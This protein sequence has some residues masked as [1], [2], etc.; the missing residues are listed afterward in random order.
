MRLGEGGG[1]L[2]AAGIRVHRDSG[3]LAHTDSL[4][5]VYVDAFGAPPWH[6]DEARATGFVS[7]LSADVRRAGF[8][9]AIA[10]CDGE[11]VGF[12]TAWTTP[13]PFPTNRCHPEAAAGLGRDRTADWLCGGREIDELAVRPAAHGTGLAGRLLEAVT[14]DAPEGRAWLLTSVRSG[15]ALAFYRRHGWT[16]ATHP[17]PGGKGIVVFL[18]PHHPARSLAPLPL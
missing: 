9:A 18:G 10:V 15:R 11:V 12:A 16:Q 7:R 4:R 5:S 13:A 2:T 14:A 17:S 1:R 8:T 6:E 3:I